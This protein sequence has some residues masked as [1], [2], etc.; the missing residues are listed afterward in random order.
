MQQCFVPC[1]IKKNYSNKV[2][3]ELVEMEAH[4]LLLGRPWQFDNKTTHHGEKN[5][6]A[7]YKNGLK[8]VLAPMKEEE[9]V[10]SKVKQEQSYVTV[11]CFLN[12][13]EAN[14][15]AFFLLA[16]RSLRRPARCF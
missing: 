8:V 11:Q 7:F 9:F 1:S 3:Y 5:V 16:Q 6:Y 14:G 4:H 2:L 15:V 12:G 10:K 13:Y